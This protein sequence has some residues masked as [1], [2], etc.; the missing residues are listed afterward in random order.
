MGHHEVHTSR[1]KTNRLVLAV[2]L[3]STEYPI[4]ELDTKVLSEIVAEQIPASGLVNLEL[5]R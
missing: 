4:C 1:R 2:G 5:S 3:E